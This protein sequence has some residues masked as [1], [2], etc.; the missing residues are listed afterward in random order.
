MAGV[1]FAAIVVVLMILPW[2][3][4]WTPRTGEPAVAAQ[5]TPPPQ[6]T[7][8][9]PSPRDPAPQPAEKASTSSD[10]KDSVSERAAPPTGQDNPLTSPAQPQRR[11]KKERPIIAS[12]FEQQFSAGFSQTA[13]VSTQDQ[14][15]QPAPPSSV[16]EPVLLSQ[17]Q[18]AYTPEAKEARIQGTVEV[19]IT[20]RAD[21]TVK[22][23]QIKK[24]LDPG[25]D[26]SAMAAVEEWKFR[27]GTRDG[28]PVATMVSVL[29]NFSLR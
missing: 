24:S 17:V 12:E 20:V 23:E 10:R 21:G 28:K 27:P 25:L 11:P 4:L 6:P 3:V 26:A 14:N 19:L 5:Q 2:H 29:I 1:T 9:E 18:P 16:T 15:P 22:A 13:A 8:P 7:G